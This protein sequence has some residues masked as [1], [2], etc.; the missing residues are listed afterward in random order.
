MVNI[1]KNGSNTRAREF[2]ESLKGLVCETPHARGWAD[3]FLPVLQVPKKSAKA[4]PI[5]QKCLQIAYKF[6][7]EKSPLFFE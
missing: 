5:F 2:L 7:K 3:V 1:H 6:E 4:A